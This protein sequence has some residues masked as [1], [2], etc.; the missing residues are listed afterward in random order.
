MEDASRIGE[1]KKV[2]EVEITRPPKKPLEG[3]GLYLASKKYYIPHILR[4]EDYGA[5]QH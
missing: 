4:Y 3:Q 5:F 2:N 1:I